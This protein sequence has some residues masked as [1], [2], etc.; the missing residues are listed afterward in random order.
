[1]DA[2]FLRPHNLGWLRRP[3]L[4][5]IH[6]D[7]WELPDGRLYASR[8]GATPKLMKLFGAIYELSGPDDH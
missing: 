7:V 1:M 5:T 4:D 6:D 8:P 2:L 3:E